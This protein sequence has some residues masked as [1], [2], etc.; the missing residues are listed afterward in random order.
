MMSSGT[1]LSAVRP[2]PS[3]TSWSGITSANSDLLF[4]QSFLFNFGSCERSSFKS[5]DWVNLFVNPRCRKISR[6]TT[7]R[8]YSL[9]TLS[10]LVKRLPELCL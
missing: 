4:S 7:A 10:R 5:F 1:S 2:D 9:F 6:A 3:Y 8:G